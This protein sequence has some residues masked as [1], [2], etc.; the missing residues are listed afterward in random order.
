MNA[1]GSIYAVSC[2][3]D[4]R[5]SFFLHVSAHAV[6]PSRFRGSLLAICLLASVRWLFT[7][8]PAGFGAQNH[9]VDGGSAAGAIAIGARIA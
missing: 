1:G 7:L 3:P 8:V 4:V 9:A 6:C 5:D 2:S